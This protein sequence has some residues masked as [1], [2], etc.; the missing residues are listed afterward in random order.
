MKLTTSLK[1]KA[2]RFIQQFGYQIV[3]RPEFRAPAIHPDWL[4]HFL[5]FKEVCDSIANVEGD[6]VECGVGY[7]NSLFKLCYLAYYEGKGRKIYGF[8]S[9]H[10]FPDPSAEDDSCRN[11]QK[12]QWNVSTA[13]GIYKFLADPRN[14]KKEF[15][16]KNVI[17]VEGF[18]EESLVKYDGKSIAFLHLDVDLY[19][20]YK[21]TLEYF[22][23]IVAK[24]GA[25]LFNEYKNALFPFLGASK[26]IDEF[27]GDRANQIQYH[28]RANRYYQAIVELLEIRSAGLLCCLL[29]PD[30]GG[31]TAWRRWHQ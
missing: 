18:F 28:E 11:P 13:N 30:C 9:F 10:G 21:M 14:F 12:G 17:L 4:A 16:Q 5:Y 26:A 25:V 7:G 22:W 3:K 1:S 29:S 15:I 19:K 20:S 27:L 31:R 6:I 24:E 23:P 8:D 2:Q